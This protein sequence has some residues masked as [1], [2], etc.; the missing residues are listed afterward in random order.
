MKIPLRELTYKYKYDSLRVLQ[1]KFCF[2]FIQYAQEGKVR[3]KGR[4]FRNPGQK[5]TIH[6]TF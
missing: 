6:N 3:A 2:L 4:K 5:V 1:Y